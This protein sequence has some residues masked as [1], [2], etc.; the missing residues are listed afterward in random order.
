MV[1]DPAKQLPIAGLVW[2][3][4]ERVPGDIR[5]SPIKLAVDHRECLCRPGLVRGKR[6]SREIVASRLAVTTSR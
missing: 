2:V 5:I 4:E 3:W 1:V 6:T